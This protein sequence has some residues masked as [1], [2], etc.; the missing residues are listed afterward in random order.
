MAFEPDFTPG[1]PAPPLRRVRRG[2]WLAGVCQGFARRWDLNVAQV[3]ALFVLSSVLAGAGLLVYVA[4]WLVLPLDEDRGERPS[5]VR[6]LASLAL[7]AAG[8]AGMTTIAMAS[9]LM[10]VFGFAWAVALAGGVFLVAALVAS[11]VVRPA[12]TLAVLAA[13]VVPAVAVATSGVSVEPQTGLVTHAPSTVTDVPKDGYHAG[14]GDLFVD[15]RRFEASAGSTVPLRL[16]TGTGRTVV[17]LPRNRCLNLDVRYRASNGGA[18]SRVLGR[19][20]AQLALFYGENLPLAGHW[21]RRSKD[22]HAATLKIEYTAV[23]GTL[24]VRDYPLTT[25]PLYDARWPENLRAPPSPGNLRWA[26]RKTVHKPSVQR[27][28]RIWRERMARF[29]R[30]R[31]RMRAGA[32]ARHTSPQ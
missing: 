29:Q 19:H 30:D 23:A 15:L 26:W 20:R 7:L 4:C 21:R 12:W 27:R 17:A 10:A 5:F 9:S 13:A 16:D 22:P 25:G 32:C 8:V 14:L 1:A 28:W 3:R 31:D 11:P 18:L 6:G 24:V 2:R